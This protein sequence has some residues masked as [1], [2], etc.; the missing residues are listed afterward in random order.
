MFQILGL[1]EGWR[2]IERFG[3]RVSSFKG[4]YIQSPAQDN[5]CILCA[6]ETKRAHSSTSRLGPKDRQ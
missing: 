5:H 6:Q 1:W 3:G 4:I 2:Y